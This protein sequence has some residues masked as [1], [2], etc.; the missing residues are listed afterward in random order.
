MWYLDRHF[1]L[2]LLCQFEQTTTVS[3]D[4]YFSEDKK[5]IKYEWAS[6]E[7]MRS[8]TNIRAKYNTNKWLLLNMENQHWKLLV[9]LTGRS[10]FWLGQ[11]FQVLCKIIIVHNSDWRRNTTVFVWNKM[12]FG[13]NA[14]L[15]GIPV[16][17]WKGHCTP[18]QSI[19]WT[20]FA[21][22][23]STLNILSQLYWHFFPVE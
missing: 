2:C 7:Y 23:K 1:K 19:Y 11:T 6:L 8:K 4:F 5:S 22:K 10:P 18:S 12:C 9:T 3:T 20:C 17:Q 16:L 15:C 14:F 13:N 21:N